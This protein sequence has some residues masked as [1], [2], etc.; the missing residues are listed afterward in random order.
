MT[1]GYLK[2]AGLAEVN[3]TRLYYEIAG[4]GH[5]L[6]LIHAGICDRRMWDDQWDAFARRYEVIR[7]D[8]RGM[9]KSDVAPG[10]FAYWEDLDGLLHYLGIERTYLAGVSVGGA[11]ALDFTL[12][13][14]TMVDALILV[15]AG[16]SGQERPSDELIQR[17]AKVQAALEAGDLSDANELMLRMWVDGP[18]RTSDQVDP[19]VRARVSTMNAQNLTMGSAQLQPRQLDPPAIDRLEEI[20]IPTLIV[21][22]DQDQPDVVT[23]ADVLATRIPRAI[24][25]VMP[26][27]AH[28]PSMERPEDFNRLVLNF[29]S[30]LP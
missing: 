18:N 8:L 21:V 5:P 25:V 20:Q 6:V 27:T 12:A 2:T 3:G 30:T 16:I 15:A 9:G 24:K 26:G 28:V 19:D 4:Q 13:H 22:G 11:T 7:F 14:A 17:W 1:D 10:A 23:T 29:L